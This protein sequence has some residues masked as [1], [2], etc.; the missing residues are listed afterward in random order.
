MLCPTGFAASSIGAYFVCKQ[1]N[2]YRLYGPGGGA[3]T[4]AAISMVNLSVCKVIKDI[5]RDRFMRLWA[6]DGLT[7][8][9]IAVLP[10]LWGS[11]AEWVLV[12]YTNRIGDLQNMHSWL[13]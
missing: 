4:I 9:Y 5:A 7:A 11:G 8:G 3:W 12:N 10:R 1:A 6:H 2:G 13:T